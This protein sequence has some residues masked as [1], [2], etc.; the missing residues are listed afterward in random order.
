MKPQT[1]PEQTHE[2]TLILTGFAELTPE[3]ENSLFEAGCDDATLGIQHGRPYLTFSRTSPSLE[4]AVRSAIGDVRSA[5][6]EADVGP[7]LEVK[8]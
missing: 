8:R 3:V 7:R 2:F 5:G 1:P 4:S 6:F